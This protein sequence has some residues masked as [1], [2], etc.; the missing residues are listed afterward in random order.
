MIFL[1]TDFGCDGPYVGQVRAVLA[2]QALMVP[3][4]ELFSDLPAFDAKSAAYLLP[5][6]SQQ[7]NP[8]DVVMAVVDPGVGSDRACIALQADGVWFVGPDNGLLAQ[9]VRR[10]KKCKAWRLPV[11]SAASASFHGRDVFAPAAAQL[12]LGQ[13][14]DAHPI[15]AAQLD[16]P[17]WPD[18]LAAVVYIDRY[19]NAMTGLR[20]ASNGAIDSMTAG[21]MRLMPKRT[22][23]DAAHGEAF[24]YVNANGLW[25]IALNGGSAAER[26]NLR[27]GV[28][29]GG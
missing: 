29:V 13:M 20:V 15:D 1:F 10:A 25:E 14:P 26:L 4:I 18:D 8:G 6:Y 17:E 16:R 24:I 23:A 5:A 11:P 9:V 21:G 7:A 19:G 27:V 22:F 28:E 12:A 3:V 2:R